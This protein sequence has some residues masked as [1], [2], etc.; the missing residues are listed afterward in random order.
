DSISTPTRSLPLGANCL[1]VSAALCA[2]APAAKPSTAEAAMNTAA[3]DDRMLMS[4]LT[5]WCLV[6]HRRRRA[7]PADAGFAV[8]APTYPLG[9]DIFPSFSNK[10]LPARCD[11]SIAPSGAPIWRCFST[12]SNANTRHQQ[13]KELCWFF[14]DRSCPENRGAAGGTRISSSDKVAANKTYSPRFLLSMTP[15]VVRQYGAIDHDEPTPVRVH[16]CGRAACPR[17]KSSRGDLRSPYQGRARHRPLGWA[18]CDPRRCG[19]RR[20]D[21]RGPNRH[22]A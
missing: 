20:Q 16:G 9:L 21:R 19:C 18:R 14:R 8:F 10:R 15:T 11:R 3:V 4:N 6:A 7:G 2:L 5:N 13:I 22:L 17:S 1:A 12:C